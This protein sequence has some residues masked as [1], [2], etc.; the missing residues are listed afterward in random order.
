MALEPPD[1]EAEIQSNHLE[2]NFNMFKHKLSRNSVIVNKN[3][4]KLFTLV[5]DVN[6]A[7]FHINIK[8]NLLLHNK[9]VKE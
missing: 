6:H 1:T 5:Y 8:K 2:G 4:K 7:Y 9:H 3:Q